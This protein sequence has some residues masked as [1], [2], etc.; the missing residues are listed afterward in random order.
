M[1]PCSVAYGQSVSFFSPTLAF[2]IVGQHREVEKLKFFCIN[3]SM[4]SQGLIAFARETL[5]LPSSAVLVRL[6]DAV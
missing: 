5:R 3:F 1:S 4:C 2:K 6:P